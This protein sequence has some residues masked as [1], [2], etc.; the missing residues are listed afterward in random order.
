MEGTIPLALF[1]PLSP[2]SELGSL[3]SPGSAPWDSDPLLSMALQD[4][5]DE[6]S[7]AGTGARIVLACARGDLQTMSCGR[8]GAGR[9]KVQGLSVLEQREPLN[10]RGV[11]GAPIHGVAGWTGSFLLY[12]DWGYI[13][14]Q[15]EYAALARAYGARV[16]GELRSSESRLKLIRGASE[17]MMLMLAAYHLPTVRHGQTVRS[18]ALLL[19]RTLQMPARELAE[20][21]V[22]A[23]MHDV[24]KIGVPQTVLESGG[25]LRDPE[26][27]AIRCHPASGDRLVRAVPALAFAASAIRYHHERWDGTGYPDRLTGDAIPFHA[28][29]ISLADAYDAMRTGRPYQEPRTPEEVILELRQGMGSQFD[30]GLASLLPAFSRHEVS[31]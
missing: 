4:I 14:S 2:A 6:A 7:A 3:G 27:A 24:G 29:L 28:R 19:G 13:T 5:V 30:P 8:S 1:V 31:I 20:L 23:L 25:S 22:E 15:R 12:Y 21:G 18:I 17:A 11:A 9:W 26:W 10:E 16:E